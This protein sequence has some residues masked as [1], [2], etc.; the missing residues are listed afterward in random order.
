[1]ELSKEQIKKHGKEIL[2]WANGEKIEFHC[3]LS[4]EWIE[5]GPPRWK[6]NTE[7]RVKPKPLFVNDLGEEFHEGVE[8]NLYWYSL[9]EG[10]TYSHKNKDDSSFYNETTN[11]AQVSKSEIGALKLAIQKLEKQNE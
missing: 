11:D 8:Y 1:M 2:A 3:V 9:S 10:M 7:Y 4:D 5:T 6:T